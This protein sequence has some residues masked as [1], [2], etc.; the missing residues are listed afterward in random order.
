MLHV[1]VPSFYTFTNSVTV[2][3]ILSVEGTRVVYVPTVRGSNLF[4]E[5]GILISARSPK[6]FT[7][8]CWFFSWRTVE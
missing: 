7:G 6:S 3:P 5:S 4:T 8:F 2:I 1:T